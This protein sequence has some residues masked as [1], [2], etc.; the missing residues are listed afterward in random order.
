MDSLHFMLE[1]RK[2]ASCLD[3]SCNVGCVDR[4]LTILGNL[5]LAFEGSGGGDWGSGCPLRERTGQLLHPIEVDAVVAGQHSI[6]GM[7]GSH[8]QAGCVVA[9][10]Q[11]QTD[12][13]SGLQQGQG[14]GVEEMV[15]VAAARV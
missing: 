2:N 1:L 8:A 5:A 13:Q 6:E 14:D 12:A 3:H 11:S 9:L 15:E 4:D 10:S 7:P